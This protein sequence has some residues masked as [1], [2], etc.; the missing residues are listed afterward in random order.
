MYVEAAYPFSSLVLDVE[1]PGRSPPVRVTI[2]L[3][4]A[5]TA[6]AVLGSVTAPAAGRNGRST[7]A[8]P[9]GSE[10]ARLGGPDGSGAAVGRWPF[11]LSR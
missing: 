10:L 3:G 9:G 6:G 2:G 8:V 11:P 7:G 5:R 1:L 4:T